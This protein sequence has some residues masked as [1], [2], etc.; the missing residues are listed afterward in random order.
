MTAELSTMINVNG[1]AL[2]WVW[3]GLGELPGVINAANGLAT[4]ILDLSIY[5]N[6]IVSYLPFTLGA[7]PSYLCKVLIVALVTSVN[8]LG[9]EAVSTVSVCL[10]VI[11]MG[12]FFVEI[13][14]AIFHF[15]SAS[16]TKTP[17]NIDWALLSSVL[18]WANTG[19]DSLGTFA[20]EVHTPSKTY[21]RGIALT[22]IA[23]SSAYIGPVVL[24]Y[25]L[26]PSCNLWENDGFL[27]AAEKT[28]YAVAVWMTVAASLSN[29]GKLNAGVATTSRLMWAM[30]AKIQEDG[31]S[32]RTLPS[33]FGKL[34][35]R[36]GTPTTALFVQF[37]VASIFCQFDFSTIVQVEMLLNCL[38]LGFEFAAF[39]RLRYTEPDTP[40]P[41]L[42]SGGMA[43]AWFITIIKSIVVVFTVVSIVWRRPMAFLGMIVFNCFVIT[44]YTIRRFYRKKYRGE[45]T[46][47]SSSLRHAILGAA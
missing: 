24:S 34:S 10:L 9:L 47:S 21:P 39:M 44:T 29:V 23:N 7:L 6:L 18:L 13:P 38:C 15:Q 42:V 1:G 5:P 8:V 20:G 31:V 27:Q 3:R 41:F 36:F 11:S 22:L 37:I 28:S 30:G 19:Y 35:P 25:I 4:S 45:L 2:V 46:R 17:A 33:M 40:R 43:G 12:V 14:Y 32:M 26:L 16:W